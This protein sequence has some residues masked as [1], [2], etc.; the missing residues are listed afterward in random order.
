[1]FAVAASVGAAAAMKDV[2]GGSVLVLPEN[3]RL[4]HLPAAPA[5]VAPLA[6]SDVA[7]VLARVLD[8][9]VRDEASSQ[10][11]PGG[12]V[13]QRPDSLVLF[14]VENLSASLARNLK[15]GNLMGGS[16]LPL[17][18]STDASAETLVG[19]VPQ[20][21]STRFDDEALIVC[22]SGSSDVAGA[23]STPS[24]SLLIPGV[25]V[26][27]DANAAASPESALWKDLQAAGG[28]VEFNGAENS[29]VVR[30]PSGDSFEFDLSEESHND[31][32]EELEL[33]S[34]VE[35]LLRSFPESA[36]RLVNGAASPGLAVLS[37]SSFAA[38]RGTD[39]EKVAAV[40]L[41]SAL[42][43]LQRAWAKMR[44]T[45]GASVVWTNALMDGSFAPPRSGRRLLT[46][47]A[48][49]VGSGAT[50]PH[51]EAEWATEWSMFQI[52]VWFSVGMAFV[53]YWTSAALF[54]VDYGQDDA[55]LFSKF[56]PDS[57]DGENAF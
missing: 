53:L 13:F 40:M 5:E 27:V 7:T 26:A 25:I 8:V 34:S 9:P 33:F 14:A 47:D 6:G 29:V 1:M 16:A 56:K 51:L 44:R 41:D 10:A 52:Q 24:A 22:A 30:I 31:F 39:A 42:P 4:V 38:L 45:D 12:N 50:N 20:L 49:D 55:G 19:D 11:L 48:S 17:E 32:F 36:D 23:C 57:G 37:F 3:S 46:T 15:L 2:A 35:A 21:L 43:A 54:N 28:S 18:A